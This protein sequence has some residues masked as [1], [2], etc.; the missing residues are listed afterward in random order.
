MIQPATP[1][2]PWLVADIGGTNARFA[3]VLSPGAEPERVQVFACADFPGLAAAAAQYLTQQGG[4]S[5]SAA[6]VA[7]AGPVTGDRFK[8]TNSHWDFSV[9][10]T[11]VSLGL[12]ALYLVN[13]FTALARSL[14]RLRAEDVRK[15]GGGEPVAGAA[16]AVVGPGTGLGVGGLLPVGRR[17]V[18]VSGEG[19]HVDLSP[20]TGREMR[21]VSALIGD[22]GAATG[23]CVLSGGGLERAYRLL[24]GF[25]GQQRSLSAA[26]ITEAGLNRSD[27]HARE[28]LT[29]FC[30]LLGG[31]AG[32]IALTFG[33]RGGVYIGGGIPPRIADF[34][35]LS[36]FR[37]RFENKYRMAAYAAAIPTYLI[38]AATPAL[39]GAAAWLDDHLEAAA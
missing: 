32:N 18:P 15:I 30:G 21:L 20:V 12:D 33:A 1:A 31:L 28:T 7:V 8:L 35:A 17:W 38:L 11:R 2:R 3:L 25:D 29:L 37:P 26:E 14:P 16:L 6:C 24:T 34:L 23:E 13:D 10:E 39:A 36:Q 19:G 27:P 22:Q 4:V 9:E 5:P